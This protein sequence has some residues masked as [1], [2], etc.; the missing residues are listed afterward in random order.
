MVPETQDVITLRFE[1]AG[2]GGVLFDTFRVGRAVN[3]D[4]Q[5][6]SKAEKVRDVGTYGT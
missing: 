1:I 4:N 3:F 2:A 6:T 5:L